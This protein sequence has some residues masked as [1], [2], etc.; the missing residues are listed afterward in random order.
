MANDEKIINWNVVRQ[1][2][3]IKHLQSPVL[4]LGRSV[5]EGGRKQ[6]P[7]RQEGAGPEL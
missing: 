7:R 4:A 1:K 3:W 6:T 5:E 2:L